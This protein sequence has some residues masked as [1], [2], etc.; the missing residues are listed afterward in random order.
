M[1]RLRRLTTAADQ[2]RICKCFGG[3]HCLVFV[4][5]S[6]RCRRRGSGLRRLR[7]PAP[8]YRL[9]PRNNE[10][11]SGSRAGP[12]MQKEADGMRA[13]VAFEH[14]DGDTLRPAV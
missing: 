5:C 3:M 12:S 6:H 10:I 9:T 4:A 8:I 11:L 1:P 14:Q 2:A 13:A 7:T